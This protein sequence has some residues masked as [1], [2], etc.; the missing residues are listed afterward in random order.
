METQHTPRTTRPLPLRGQRILV[1]GKGGSGKSSLVALLARALAGRG[2]RV[3]ALDGDASNPGGLARL[4]L[5]KAT[6]PRPLI[7]FFGGRERVECPVDDPSPLTRLG[8]TAPVAE[9]PIRLDELPGEYKLEEQGITLLRVGKITHALEGCEGPMS[10]VTRDLR[11]AGDV[12]TLVDVEAGIEHFGR[13]VERHIDTVVVVVDPTFESLDIADRI[14]ELC[15]QM[16]VPGLGAV[17]N[18]ARPTV[19]EAIAARLQDAEIP[20]LGAV[21]WDAALEDAGFEGRALPLTPVE[22]AVV[23][24]IEGLEQAAAAREHRP[25]NRGDDRR[26]VTPAQA[27]A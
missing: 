6:Q 23:T 14:A 2:Y 1:C 8:D 16:D 13:G 7:E 21:D 26:V 15:R 18:R 3:V 5:G 25:P 9:A 20:V 27:P 19:R 4:V 10:K 17:I 11:I 12:V 24:I 22:A